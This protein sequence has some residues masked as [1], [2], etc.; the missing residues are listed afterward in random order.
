MITL[1]LAVGFAVVGIAGAANAHHNTITGSVACKDGGGWAVTWTVVNSEPISETITYSSRGVVPAGTTLSGHQTRTFTETVT[2]KPTEPLT[3]RLTAKW[4]NGYTRTNSGSVAVAKFTDKCDVKIV[5]PPTVPV[6]DPCGPNNAT[7][8]SVPSGPWTYVINGNGSITIT[9]NPGHQFPGGTTTVTLPPPTDSNQPCPPTTVQPPT[10]PVVDPCG[11]NNATYGPVPSGPW[12]YVINGN[13]S[14]TITANPGHQFPGG[15]T[16][17]TLPPP[18]DSNVPCP[19]TPPVN[20]PVNPPVLTPPVVVPP[21]VLPAQVRVVRAQARK[22][23]KCGRSGDRFRVAE[24]SGVI[25][26]SRGKVLREGTW[27]RATTRSI[28]VRAYAAD[29]TFRLEGKQVWRMTF[30]TRPCASAPEIAPNTG[31]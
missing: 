4:D 29:A 31:M 21:E 23:D 9:A 16:T 25:Y 22:I 26:K 30:S 11:P 24:R 13:G 6:L 1:V 14:I 2:T 27:L 10:V 28:T 15:T 20:P 19:V 17:V 18:S 3:L 8:G 7:Y 12:T 5:E